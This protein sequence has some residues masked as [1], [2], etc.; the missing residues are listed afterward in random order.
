MT[1]TEQMYVELAQRTGGGMDVVL[2]WRRDTREVAVCV[3]DEQADVYF[4]I[5]APADRALDVFEHPYA[6]LGF[7]AEFDSPEHD[8]AAVIASAAAAVEGGSKE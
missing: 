5:P 4:E 8:L 1:V 2:Y 7:D 3:A 6:Y